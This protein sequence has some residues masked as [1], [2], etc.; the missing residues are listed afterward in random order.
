MAYIYSAPPLLSFSV[1]AFA[2]SGAK[3]ANM[4]NHIPGDQEYL[5]QFFVSGW[6]SK[7]MHSKGVRGPCCSGPWATC[8]LIREV[9]VATMKWNAISSLS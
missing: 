5:E 9:K 8:F 2:N 4:Q 7:R 1:L 3:W 6:D